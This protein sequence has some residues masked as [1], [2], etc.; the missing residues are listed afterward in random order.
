MCDVRIFNII[1]LNK[2]VVK[3]RITVSFAGL[4]NKEDKE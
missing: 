4:R 2:S 1:H 3:L